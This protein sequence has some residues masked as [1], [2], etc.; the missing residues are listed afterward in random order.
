M[1]VKKQNVLIVGSGA[2]E[3]ALA[4]KLKQSPR[5]GELYVA[6]GNAGTAEIAENVAVKATDIGGLLAFVKSTRI[7][8]TVV[9][10]D[11]PLRMGI[12][13]VFRGEGLCIFGPTAAAA[14]I[15]W[16]KAYAKR[17]MREV[18]IPTADFVVCENAKDALAHVR[19]R[20]LPFVVKADG[21]AAGKGVRVCRTRRA[22]EA[23]VRELMVDGVREPDAG[24]VIEDCLDGDEVSVHVLTDGR[25]HTFLPTAQDHKRLRD[26]GLGPMT[27]G[28]GTIAPVPGIEGKDL[29]RIN[30]EIIIPALDMLRRKGSPFNGCLFTGLM[31][32]KDGPKV[33]EFNARFGDPE[34]QAIL[35]IVEADLLIL[36]E[37]CAKRTLSGLR[38]GTFELADPI[39]LN[40]A[41][42]IVLASKGY[43]DS[44]RTGVPITV[45][46][47]G[48]PWGG[49]IFHAGTARKDGQLVT[50][51]GRVMS[52]MLDQ[53]ALSKAVSR[54]YL[55]VEQ[56]SFP[57]MQFR[58]DIGKQALARESD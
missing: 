56:V 27:G 29:S 45:D 42:C 10:P 35:P 40:S 20:P 15:E 6:P 31:M 48:A 43:P 41:A 57:G 34:A 55:L 1:E 5:C 51:G 30:R 47:R 12:V 44:P 2:R 26:G 19:S 38:Y 21:L 24:V 16:S 28:M 11:E 58:R 32:T 53:P 7:D 36:L 8:L 18:G 14:R 9:G 17:L 50:D 49:H 3:H 39:G 13:N 54:A 33:L 37:R 25:T 23:A 46:P 52:V 22:A 4:W